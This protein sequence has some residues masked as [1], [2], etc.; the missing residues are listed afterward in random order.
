MACTG[1]SDFRNDAYDS[2]CKEQGLPPISYRFDHD[3]CTHRRPNA[4][5]D[6]IAKLGQKGCREGKLGHDRLFCCAE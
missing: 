6:V 4:C 3:D 5:G 1:P 2:F